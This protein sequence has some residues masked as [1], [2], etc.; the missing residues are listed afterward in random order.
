MGLGFYTY[1][2]PIGCKETAT[3]FYFDL[4]S[5]NEYTIYYR[6]NNVDLFQDWIEILKKQ[7]TI[8]VIE[9]MSFLK[10]YYKLDELLASGYILINGRGSFP[11]SGD[12]F[13]YKNLLEFKICL[14]SLGKKEKIMSY[15]DDQKKWAQDLL[16]EF[17]RAEGNGEIRGKFYPFVL[18][19]PMINLWEG[20]REDAI[21][22]FIENEIP[23]WEGTDDGPTGHLVSSQVACV[24][25]LFFLRQ[26]QDLATVI[27]KKIDKDIISA[28]RL[29]DGYVEFEVIGKNNYLGEHQHT[30]GANA[31]SIDAVMLGRKAKKNILV[32][33][34][35]KYT[36]NYSGES[37][38]KES[39]WKIY[40]PLLEE[41]NSPIR[42]E[43]T[44]G[45]NPDE[46]Y[47]I[48][49]YEPYYQLMRQT[50]LSWKM[51]NANEYGADDYIHLHIV[52][53]ENVEMLEGVTS[54]GLQIVG[55]DSLCMEF[56]WK[57]VLKDS[58]KYKRISP[59]NFIEPIKKEKDTKSLFQYLEK[60]YW[61]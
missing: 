22:Y 42:S 5:K 33:I 2:G 15:R 54:K 53:D 52:P 6:R 20:V 44:K 41:P 34:E 43:N 47:K 38:Y 19:K 26:R 4:L 29:D 56:A 12:C 60:R 39:R 27:L 48:L 45:D 58:S 50:I 23:W 13:H 55:D 11:T 31:T 16:P 7:D 46:Y 35:W 37:L 32:S 1:D 30:R 17:L 14:R 51:A 59:S 57:S 49:Y 18:K 3:S 61:Q 25:H 40:N 8:N 21:S 36:E 28:E 9:K 10:F 24:N